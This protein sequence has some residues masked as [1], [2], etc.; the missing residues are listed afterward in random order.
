MAKATG[1]GVI[2]A[3]VILWGAAS[4]LYDGARAGDVAMSQYPLP[5][6]DLPLLNVSTAVSADSKNDPTLNPDSIA[7]GEPYLLNFWA[8]WCV[9]CQAESRFLRMISDEVPIVGVAL[10]DAPDAATRWLREFGSP[11]QFSYIDA[12]GHY[13]EQLGVQGAPETFLI[14]GDG[15]VRFHYQGLL[16]ET[17][18]RERVMPI[19]LGLRDE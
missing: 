13:A 9:T 2:L 11:Y 4:A 10:K 15:N 7:S 16:Q 6:S 14:D 18:W 5:R 1:F 3:T 17:V 19:L 12:D 8:S